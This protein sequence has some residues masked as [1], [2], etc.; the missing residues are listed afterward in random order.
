MFELIKFI[1]LNFGDILWGVPLLVI[2]YNSFTIAGGNKIITLERRWFGRQ[3]PDGRTVALS[4]EVG[5]QARVL[6]PGFHF[7][8]PFIFRTTK[9]HFLVIPSNQVGVVRAITGAPIPSGNYMAKSIDCDL[10]QDGEAFLRN[11][12]E[13]GPQLAILPEGE[14]KINPALFEVTIVDAIMIDDN[15]VGYVEAIAGNPVTRPGGNFGSPVACDNFQDAQAFI[16]NGGQKGPQISFL[17]PGFYRINTILFH[18]EKRPITEIKGGQIGLVEATDGARIPEGRLL[19]LKVHGHN[20][21]YDGEA[22]IKSGGEKGRQL[23]VLMPGR[24]RINPALFK[25]ISVVD[26][27]NIEADQVMRRESTPMM[28]TIMSNTKGITKVHATTIVTT[29][30]MTVVTTAMTTTIMIGKARR[31]TT[32][33]RAR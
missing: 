25:V 33:S 32:R 21:F 8:I 13:K 12:G 6:G 24:Y 5:V 3:M 29:L 4:H 22:F 30:M 7:L 1:A 9:H 2:L 17:T 26:W 18:I 27:T 19:A 11:G 10:F 16:D 28:T 31:R 15:E 20:S 23:D 14:Y